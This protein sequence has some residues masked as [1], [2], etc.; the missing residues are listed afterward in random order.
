MALHVTIVSVHVNETILRR[1]REQE[2]RNAKIAVS[3]CAQN[4]M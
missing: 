2:D 3:A 4:K 1:F